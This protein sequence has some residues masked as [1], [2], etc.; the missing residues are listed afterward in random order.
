[1]K[2][3]KKNL[4][5]SLSGFLFT[6]LLECYAKYKFLSLNIQAGSIFVVFLGAV[7]N[8]MWCSFQI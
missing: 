6:H 5:F 7:F 1:M 8:L 3:L 2:E 4:I